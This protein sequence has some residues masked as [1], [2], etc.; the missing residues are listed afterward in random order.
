MRS[1]LRK[2]IMKF[3]EEENQHKLSSQKKNDNQKGTI[4]FQTNHKEYYKISNKNI[5]KIMI[6]ALALSPN[7]KNHSNFD[8]KNLV[9]IIFQ[10]LLIHNYLEYMDLRSMKNS[11]W[12]VAY[13]L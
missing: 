3:C 12:Q 4:S 9:G 1:D 11:F 13:F 2:N 8:A 6:K 5:K 7:I 10:F